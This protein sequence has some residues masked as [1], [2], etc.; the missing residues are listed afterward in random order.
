VKSILYVTI[1]LILSYA[2][3]KIFV[4]KYDTIKKQMSEGRNKKVT[5]DRSIENL[6]PLIRDKVHS[7]LNKAKD[8]GFDLIV[9]SGLRTC[10]EQNKLYA[11]GRT[12]KS[13]PIVT[14]AKCGESSHN[15]GTAIDVVEVKNGKAVGYEKN[16]PLERWNKIGAIGKSFGFKWGGDWTGFKDLPHFE[17][18]F[19]N[20]L[21]QMKKKLDE[22]NIDSNGYVLV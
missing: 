12:D 16:Y 7:F 9:T 5:G 8:E 15:F 6:H 18:N 10:E 21:T 22:K 4:S 1:G 13:K 19:G 3:Y 2:I 11:Q 20:T 14:R 17:M